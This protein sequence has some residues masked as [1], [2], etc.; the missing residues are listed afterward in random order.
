VIPRA[1][2]LDG[3]ESAPATFVGLDGSNAA[4]LVEHGATDT[5]NSGDL[6]TVDTQLG[7]RFEAVHHD[8]STSGSG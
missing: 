3:H 5:K 2:F 7:K 1:Q 4:A 8:A 6:G